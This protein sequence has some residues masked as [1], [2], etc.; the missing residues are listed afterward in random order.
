MFASLV[1]LSFDMAFTVSHK[2]T[3]LSHYTQHSDHRCHSTH[4]HTHTHTHKHT[5]QFNGH[6]PCAAGLVGCHWILRSDWC[7]IF[8]AV[9]MPTRQFTH[10]AS[11]F[12][13]PLTNSQMKECHSVTPRMLALWLASLATSKPPIVFTVCDD[14][15]TAHL[16]TA[17]AQ[18]TADPI[19]FSS[20]QAMQMTT[21]TLFSISI[22][23][24]H[25]STLLPNKTS[26]AGML[27]AGHTSY[28]QNRC[29][30]SK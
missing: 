21:I 29:Q 16:H 2:M 7:N 15:C 17:S 8:P 18:L 12:H 14:N 24:A 20:S 22:Q 23:M 1:M 30:N 27:Q 11:S 28:H 5:R 6:I 13:H 10:W 25:F 9:P 26:G 4:T 3:Q 19:I